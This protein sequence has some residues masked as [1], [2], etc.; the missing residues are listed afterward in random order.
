M[1][2]SLHDVDNIPAERD[3]GYP[4]VVRIIL[5]NNHFVLLEC[6]L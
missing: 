4:L 5:F 1:D 3:S 2:H 6:H